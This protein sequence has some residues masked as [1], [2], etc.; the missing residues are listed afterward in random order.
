MF[1]FCTSLASL[2]LS[3]F[4][5]A[6][7][8]D[9]SSMFGDCWGLTTIYASDKWSTVSVTKGGDMFW[10]CN[11]L[12]GGQ[13]TKFSTSHTDFTYAHID[14]GTENPG[15]FAEK[16]VPRPYAVLSS[17]KTVL[18]FYYDQQ[19]EECNGMDVGPFY[20]NSS[21][22]YKY[23]DWYENR[24]TITSV[25][26]DTSF[27]NCTKIAST[28]YWFYG[29]GNLTAFT[30]I[31]NLN[32]YNVTD[33]S[34]MFENC[35]TLTSLDVRGF[36]TAKVTNMEMMFDGCRKLKS[37][38]LGS[39]N[40]A[41]VTNMRDMFSACSSL[42]S[43]N[44]SGFNTAN[45]TDMSKMFC[46]CSTL[47]S[48]NLSGFNTTN[49]ELMSFMFGECSSLTSIDLSSFNTA[50]V[51]SMYS[52][53]INCKNIMTI[54]VGNEWNTA[55]VTSGGEMF[56]NCTHLIGGQGTVYDGIHTGHTFAHIDGGTSN[57]GYFTYKAA[58]GIRG[59]TL[60]NT[61]GGTWY[62]LIGRSF[63]SHPTQRGLYIRDG[64]KV[65]VK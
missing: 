26:F 43:L 13:G 21:N 42:T 64:R 8:T 25:V 36:N 12:V 61:D 59:I 39:F 56:N 34:H 52:M 30:G 19:K 50:N 29:C 53:F 17:D 63:S 31:E 62:D 33:M 49:V 5:T 45:V 35:Q 10:G 41:K 48:L 11:S 14:G 9:M 27:A 4:N 32:T 20:F 60:E 58:S 54:Y 40:T 16:N 24:S 44:L 23:P 6:N 22:D 1:Y 37:L 7:V 55:S 2:N 3:N 47:T 18:K 28:A 15:Y 51:T 46:E 38:D 57:P 65:M